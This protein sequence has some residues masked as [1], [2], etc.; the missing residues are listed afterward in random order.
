MKR[1]F[2]SCQPPPPSPQVYSYHAMGY[3]TPSSTLFPL[4]LSPLS[5]C[6]DDWSLS[7]FYRL[8]FIIKQ[9]A[10]AFFVG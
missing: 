6:L 8:L 4:S 7:F 9:L 10:I 3:N 5:Q 1:L 2:R